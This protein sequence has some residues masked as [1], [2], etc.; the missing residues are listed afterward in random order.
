M[1]KRQIRTGGGGWELEVLEVFVL[2]SLPPPPP[3]PHLQHM[4]VTS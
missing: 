3:G 2:S 4:E 1:E